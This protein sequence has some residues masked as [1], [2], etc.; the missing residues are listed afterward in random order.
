MT[1]AILTV[2]ELAGVLNWSLP[3]TLALLSGP[4][5]PDEEGRLPAGRA[6]G[7][8]VFAELGGRNILTPE[9]AGM[10]AGAATHA[11]LNADRSIIL[12]WRGGQ[13]VLA[14]RN[15][16]GAL[17]PADPHQVYG[18][19]IRGPHVTVPADAML[20]DLLHSVALFRE[21]D[22]LA[23]QRLDPT[24]STGTRYDHS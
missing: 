8:L 16:G 7:A 18:A 19:P 4:F 11:D 22:R 13:P 6:L 1:T 17:P 23:V 12:A 20:A 21:R 24:G 14:W 2:A 10:M 15:A 5:A 3:D 9:L